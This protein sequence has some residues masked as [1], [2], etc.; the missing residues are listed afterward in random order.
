MNF[1]LFTIRLLAFFKN[2]FPN[3]N[4]PKIIIECS[5]LL[6]SVKLVN[7]WNIFIIIINLYFLFF[8]HLT[9]YFNHLIFFK[10]SQG[11][12]Q[13]TLTFA[14]SIL[15]PYAVTTYPINKIFSMQKIHLLRLAYS[16]LLCNTLGCLYFTIMLLM[17]WQ[18]A[19]ILQV[20]SFLGQ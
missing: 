11:Q 2:I 1:M 19:H 17:T 4:C 7:T 8:L 18:S 15:I 10:V 14:S 13:M 16:F 6:N 9:I 20:Q 3:S 5:V 12:S